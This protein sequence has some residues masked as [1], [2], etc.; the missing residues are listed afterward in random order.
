MGS[1]VIQKEGDMEEGV[2]WPGWA[3]SKHMGQ[4][5]GIHA[6]IIATRTRP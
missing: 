1:I 6:T 2:E 4:G 5:R 3:G